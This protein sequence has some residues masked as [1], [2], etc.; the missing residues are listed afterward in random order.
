[1][2]IKEIII[3]EKLQTSNT[4][5]KSNVTFEDV[6]FSDV[7]IIEKALFH[8]LHSQHAAINN[9]AH[10]QGAYELHQVILELHGKI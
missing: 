10:M 4:A 5:F 7:H 2:E 3:T 1:M 6:S 8:Y 9:E